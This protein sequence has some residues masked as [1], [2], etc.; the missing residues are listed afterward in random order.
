MVKRA[1]FKNVRSRADID[2]GNRGTD[3]IP[4]IYKLEKRLTPDGQTMKEK[5][6]TVQAHTMNECKKVFD[7]EW[8]K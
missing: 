7:E 8:K 1:N 3:F 4:L 6:L 2:K 5:Q